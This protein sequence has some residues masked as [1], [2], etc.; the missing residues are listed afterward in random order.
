MGAHG[1]GQ[2]V[3]LG[4]DE[5]MRNPTTQAACGGRSRPTR[6]EA[7]PPELLLYLSRFLDLASVIVLSTATCRNLRAIF[8]QF[9]RELLYLEPGHRLC[10]AEWREAAAQLQNHGLSTQSPADSSTPPSAIDQ[11]AK[12]KTT[13]DVARVAHELT[14]DE[15]LIDLDLLKAVLDFL[16][17]RCTS[18]VSQHIRVDA[19]MRS[20]SASGN[21]GANKIRTL[22]LSGWHGIA[23]AFLIQQLHVQPALRSVCTVVKTERADSRIWKQVAADDPTL[24]PPS[25]WP[26]TQSDPQ[27]DGESGKPGFSRCTSTQIIV[28]VGRRLPRRDGQAYLRGEGLQMGYE[29]YCIELNSPKQ[30]SVPPSDG[31]LKSSRPAIPLSPDEAAS[32]A[33]RLHVVLQG[34]EDTDATLGGWTHNEQL[35]MRSIVTCNHCKAPIRF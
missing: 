28:R 11:T 5:R 35:W 1:G 34:R 8:G 29:G 13:L 20:R 9:D 17:R 6:L 32:E 27:Q 16:S 2:H 25:F 10:L 24:V 19:V 3:R 14:R 12:P 15:S 31:P 22:H 23:G 7:L 21:A 18:E 30:L 33:D 4:E 26:S